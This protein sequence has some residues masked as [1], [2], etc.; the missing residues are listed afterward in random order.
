[1]TAGT[2]RQVEVVQDVDAKSA[3]TLDYPALAVAELFVAGVIVCNSG[4]IDATAP[5]WRN[6]NNP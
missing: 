4:E 6:R 5:G 1:L 2:D 3:T